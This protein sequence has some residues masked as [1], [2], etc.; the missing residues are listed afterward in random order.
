MTP[1]NKSFPYLLI[2]LAFFVISIRW[3]LLTQT[4]FIADDA[5]ITYRYAENLVAGNGLV[6][7]LGEK[8]LG[9]TTP[10]LTL[11]I[12][13]AVSLG[14]AAKTFAPLLNVLC[15]ALT[16]ILIVFL[17]RNHFNRPFFGF[18]VAFIYAVFPTPWIWS[19]SG[20]EVAM[21]GFCILASLYAFL[22]KRFSLSFLF[23]GCALLTRIDA[24][25]LLIAILMIAVLSKQK[26]G[27]RPWVTLLLVLGPWLLISTWYYGSP[28]PNSVIAKKVFYGE[29]PEFRSAPL[30]IIK[31]FIFGGKTNLISNF[32]S[33]LV[34]LPFILLFIF[35]LIG[36]ISLFQ[37]GLSYLILPLWLGGY[38]AFFIVGKTHMHP[39]YFSAFYAVYIPLVGLGMLTVWEK[40]SQFLVQKS[41]GLKIKKALATLVLLFCG[42]FFAFECKT[43]VYFLGEYQKTENFLTGIA[44]WVKD[45]TKEG[46]KVYYSD[47]GKLG[48]YSNRYILDSVGIVSPIVTKHYRERNWLGPI[49]EVQPELVLFA[50]TDFRL[51]E[52]LE[53][54][55]LKGMYKEI[56]QF[57][58]QKSTFYT[59]S[60][61]SESASGVEFP[62]IIA[63][64]REN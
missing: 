60:V 57:D 47:I 48:Y 20:M 13:L 7:N 62:K 54:N 58:F 18:F 15:D 4:G 11:L 49:Q 32:Y 17:F 41:M 31:G 16:A 35:A 38:V 10:L 53:D 52:F 19:I 40:I 63:Y 56:K 28:V 59:D 51:P 12:S 1:V 29:L 55:Q 64:I 61:Y 23:L 8:V 2:A 27:W 45:Q 24:L 43:L 9:T 6:Y 33:L 30:E 36:T 42:L 21:Y 37:F 44:H 34:T 3:F 5:L 26:L 14:I 46:D 39:W 25:V 50:E 22:G